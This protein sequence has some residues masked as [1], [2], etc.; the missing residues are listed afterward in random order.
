MG[1]LVLALGFVSFELG[2]VILIPKLRSL[3]KF[4]PVFA[5]KQRDYAMGVRFLVLGFV[6]L[7]LGFVVLA[8]GFV[9]CT[10]KIRGLR[11]F[12]PPSRFRARNLEKS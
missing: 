6:G 7:A 11:K 10:L 1:F 3:K 12:T 4:R 8:L 5:R 2:L 9:V